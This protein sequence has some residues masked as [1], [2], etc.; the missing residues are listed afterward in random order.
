MYDICR[1]ILLIVGEFFVFLF[2]NK[3]IIFHV[4]FILLLKVFLLGLDFGKV[5][6]FN[7][8]WVARKKMSFKQTLLFFNRLKYSFRNPGFS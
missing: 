8:K 1:Y 5:I 3:S 2:I 6:I 7:F 4:V